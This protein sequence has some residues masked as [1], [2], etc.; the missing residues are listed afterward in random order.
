MADTTTNRWL[1]VSGLERVTYNA[2]LI[3]GG[4]VVDKLIASKVTERKSKVLGDMISCTL[5]KDGSTH[6]ISAELV[7]KREVAEQNLKYGN[8]RWREKP[9]G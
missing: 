1:S 7:T 5:Q 2:P 6:L 8:I 3:D 4:H 9:N